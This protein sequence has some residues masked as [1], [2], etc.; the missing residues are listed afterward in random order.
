MALN[1]ARF[2]DPFQFGHDYLPEFTEE[3]AQFALSNI[4]GH[5]REKLFG[6]PRPRGDGRLGFPL[7][8]FAFYIASPIFAVGFAQMALRLVRRLRGG[9]KGEALPVILVGVC[10]S[11]HLLLLC[12]HAT[13]GGVQWGLRY[14]IDAIPAAVLG[15]GLLMREG[16]EG[17]LD[18]LLPPAL[19]FGLGLNL[20]GTLAIING[21]DIFV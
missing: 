11:L 12:A 6:L 17:D 3:H 15:I 16:E 10:V 18:W 4:P 14:T 9:E 20:V 2:G 19:V 5:F 8:G 13:M 1:F 21:W 7:G